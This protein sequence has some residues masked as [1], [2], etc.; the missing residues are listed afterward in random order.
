[1]YI[2]PET[3]KLLLAALRRY[4]EQKKQLQLEKLNTFDRSVDDNQA[5]A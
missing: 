2:P 1:M 3:R 4:A 5:T